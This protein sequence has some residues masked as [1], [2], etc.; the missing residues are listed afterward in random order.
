M[1][2]NIHVH[3]THLLADTDT[4]VSLY[5]KVRDLYPKSA[6]LESSDYHGKENS[7]SIIGILPLGEFRVEKGII[8]QAIHKYEKQPYAVSEV[9]VLEELDQFMHAFH[10]QNKDDKQP[11][12]GVLGYMGHEAAN[13]F[14]SY[15]RQEQTECPVEQ[16]V[17]EIYYL[18]YQF[19]ILIDPHKNELILIENCPEGEES[20]TNNLLQVL[21]NRGLPSYEFEVDGEEMSLITDQEHREGIEKAISLTQKGEL[22]QL[23]LSRSF[24][25]SF[26]GDEF[27]VY[28]SLRSINPSP[29]LFYFDFGSFRIFGS[30][31][32]THCKVSN[33]KATI[34]PI[35]GTYFRTGDDRK[36]Q[37]LAKSLLE[38]E[39]EVLEH[40]MLV[41]Y[42]L[43]DLREHCDQVEVE[44]YKQVQFYSHVIHLVSRVS[45]VI[46]PSVH[47]LEILAHTFPAGTLVGSPKLKALSTLTYLEK[48]KR[49]F[50]GGCI[51]Y[52]GLNGDLTQAI[53]IRTF[54]SKNNTLFYR[55]GGGIVAQSQPHREVQE[56]KSKLQALKSAIHYA[57]KIKR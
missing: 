1:K 40:N 2:I 20:K 41:D 6:L 24:Y 43:Q 10:I 51:G 8:Y 31:P 19:L 11:V 21:Q 56:V 34:D 5:L 55:A 22:E 50:Y 32:E 25:Q 12:N 4:P 23:V 36:D 49:G 35:A 45:G 14:Y 26:R 27:M 39:K 33:G 44:F 54:L 15:Q 18:F 17:P 9:D 57:K 53:T 52:I 42:A 38:D 7:K 16:D 46:R 13:Y 3:T 48:Y 29:Y 37:E 30:S 28:R 47:S